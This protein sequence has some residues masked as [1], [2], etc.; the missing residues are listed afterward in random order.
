MNERIGVTDDLDAAIDQRVLDVEDTLLVAWDGPRGEHNGVA[1]GQRHVAHFVARY[2]GQCGAVFTLRTGEDNDDLVPRDIAVLVFLDEARQTFHH[3][4][5]VGHVDDALQGRTKQQHLATGVAC[6][7]H[8]RSD[9]ADVRGESGDRH[10]ALCLFDH[11]AQAL[12]DF[13]LGWRDA[14]AHG[15][16]GI[17]HE[18]QYAFVTYG[19]QT[20][21]VGQRAE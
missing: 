9:A 14:V 10:P 1:I 7:F 11:F 19:A 15:V 8:D 2:L 18:S 3:A 6:S 13:L 20:G 5:I 4:E 21:L 17:A 12:R 16:G